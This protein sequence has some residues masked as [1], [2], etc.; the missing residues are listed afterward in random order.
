MSSHSHWHDNQNTE[1]ERKKHPNQN[2]ERDKNRI[3]SVLL[4]LSRVL[5][6]RTER[7]LNNIKGERGD[8]KIGQSVR[9]RFRSERNDAGPCH[10]KKEK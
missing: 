1:S 5:H 8:I 10:K 9:E 3:I 6:P 2:K 4:Y 7:S